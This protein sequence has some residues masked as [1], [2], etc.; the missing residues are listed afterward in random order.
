MG[1]YDTFGNVQ[2]K[3][4][5]CLLREF[6]IGDKVEDIAD[7]IYAGHEGFVVIFDGTFVA[8]LPLNS[9]KDKWG[10]AIEIDTDKRN[11]VW[12]VVNDAVQKYRDKDEK[13]T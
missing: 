7:G 5:E 11:P 6:K 2:L 10:E 12:A 3:N 9:M 4:G 13:N 8:E 1:M